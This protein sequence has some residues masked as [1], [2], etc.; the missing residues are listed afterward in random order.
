MLPTERSTLRKCGLSSQRISSASTAVSLLP[1]GL[2]SRLNS[3]KQRLRMMISRFLRPRDAALASCCQTGTSLDYRRGRCD[4]STILTPLGTE[5]ASPPVLAKAQRKPL[6]WLPAADSHNHADV[7]ELR[8][9]HVSAVEM[10]SIRSGDIAC[11]GAAC[12][13]AGGVLQ[14]RGA[15]ELSLAEARLRPGASG[16][17]GARRR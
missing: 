6:T 12:G 14:L 10:R 4:E 3:S 7:L 9:P 13:G 8:R 1:P 2:W 17:L 11:S 5:S 16:R 15:P